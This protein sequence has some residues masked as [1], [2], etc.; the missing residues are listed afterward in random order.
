M[1]GQ[2][3]N[4]ARDELTIRRGEPSDLMGDGSGL[5]RVAVAGFEQELIHAAAIEVC[6]LE[7]TPKRRRGDSALHARNGLVA[8]VEPCGHLFLG[9]PCLLASAGNARADSRGDLSLSC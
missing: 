2:L 8:D 9:E 5:I 4:D 6:E 1:R 3:L 7:E